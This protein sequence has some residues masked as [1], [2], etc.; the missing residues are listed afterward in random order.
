MK[1]LI[2][3]LMVV[4]LMATVG[5]CSKKVDVTGNLSGVTDPTEEAVDID[6]VL[7]FS[8]GKAEG[9]VY[10]N[11][12]IGIGY[13]LDDGWSF[14][15]EEKINQLNN[16]AVDM[17]GEEL[18]KA[19]EDATMIYDMYATDAEGLNNV[20]INLEKIGA[21][22]LAATDLKENFE[23]NAP[24]MEE[25]FTN[26]GYTNYTYEIK[27][28]VVNGETVDAMCNTADINGVTMYQTLFQKKC[29][30]YLASMCVTTFVEDTTDDLLSNFFWLD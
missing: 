5:A 15:D 21:V 26:M 9:T 1:K 20:N 14:Y 8:L 29:G 12:F 3:I 19:M 30:E 4:L 2:A 7:D 23:L 11:E 13:N 10:T 27:S 25:A 16:L 6:E 24:M 17:A 22:Q 18:Q 28:I